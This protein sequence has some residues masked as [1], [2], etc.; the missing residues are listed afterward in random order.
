MLCRFLSAGISNL[1]FFFLMPSCLKCDIGV[2]APKLGLRTGLDRGSVVSEDVA[3]IH[4][5]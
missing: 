5:P 1:A 3:D 2:V 4:P